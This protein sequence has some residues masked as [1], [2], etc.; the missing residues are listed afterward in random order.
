MKLTL[1]AIGR[2]SKG[3][4]AE[5]CAKMAARVDAFARVTRLGPIDLKAIEPK[6]ADRGPHGEAVLLRRAVAECDR[7]AAFDERGQALS[8]SAFAS[9]LERWRDGGAARL[10]LVIG[11][12]DGLDPALRGEADL[13]ISFGAMTWP[14]ALARVMALEQIYRAATILAGHPYHREG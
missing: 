6:A 14:H 10:G 12:A 1:A 11:G 7:L 4:E 13:V 3:P 2:L 9:N 8:S 5:L